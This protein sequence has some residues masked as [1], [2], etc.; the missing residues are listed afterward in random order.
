[1]RS[2]RAV[3]LRTVTDPLERASILSQVGA[4]RLT[5]SF[6]SQIGAMYRTPASRFG[7]E[8]PY[9]CSLCVPDA[10]H[11]AV[12]RCCGL[13]RLATDQRVRPDP[14]PALCIG[15]PAARHHGRGCRPGALRADGATSVASSL[16]A[17]LTEIHLCN[18]CS[19]QETFDEA[20]AAARCWSPSCRT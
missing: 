11:G 4:M 19:G 10:S 14:H 13:P 1:V 6:L 5:I 7:V 12:L 9:V 8:C 18:V 2:R 17:V 16:A 20:T 3:D 15:A